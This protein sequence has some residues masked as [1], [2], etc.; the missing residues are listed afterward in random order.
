[1]SNERL[2]TLLINSLIYIDT[3]LIQTINPEENDIIKFLKDEIGFTDEEIEE[4]G[5]TDDVFPEIKGNKKSF[6]N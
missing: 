6:L 5:I 4:L 3:E 1:M 2:K